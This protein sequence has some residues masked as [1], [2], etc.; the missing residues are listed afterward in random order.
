MTVELFIEDDITGS[1]TD[2]AMEFIQDQL[3]N[4][5]SVDDLIGSMLCC[6][7]AILEHD[8]MEQREL[9]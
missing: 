3:D 6:I 7:A 9:M 1:V 2:E 4:G 8:N 5:V